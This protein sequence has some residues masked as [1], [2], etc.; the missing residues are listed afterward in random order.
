M[1][2]GELIL[3]AVFLAVGFSIGMTILSF[4]TTVLF[5]IGGFVVEGFNRLLGRK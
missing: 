1:N 3:F 5:I 4:M 2:F